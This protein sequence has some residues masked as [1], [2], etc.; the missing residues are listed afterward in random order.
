MGVK[1]RGLSEISNLWLV[2]SGVG[3][4]QGYRGLGVE[5]QW[6]EGPHETSKYDGKSLNNPN[7]MTKYYCLIQSCANI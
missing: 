6:V 7:K 1:L 3:G 4:G 5:D 2:G